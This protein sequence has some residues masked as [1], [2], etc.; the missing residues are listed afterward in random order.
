MHAVNIFKALFPYVMPCTQLEEEEEAVPSSCRFCL[1][2]WYCFGWCE[3]I[4]ATLAPNNVVHGGYTGCASAHAKWKPKGESSIYLLGEVNM[5]RELTGLS[6]LATSSIN[7]WLTGCGQHKGSTLLLFSPQ[8]NTKF[9]FL[10][11]QNK[12]ISRGYLYN[13][14][15][16]MV[17]I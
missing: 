5:K 15:D 17:I 3:M 2:I 6:H 13:T 8:A 9:F 10:W 14:T 12:F 1:Q 11:R 16:T 7:T 4:V